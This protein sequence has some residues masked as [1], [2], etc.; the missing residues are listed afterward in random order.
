M[1]GKGKARKEWYGKS[2]KDN[3]G[4]ERKCEG[5]QGESGRVVGGEIR[6]ER[7]KERQKQR[8]A[9]KRRAYQAAR[10]AERE[11][12]Q[13]VIDVKER[14]FIHRTGKIDVMGDG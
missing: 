12:I 6:E 1:R 2:L 13:R 3:G 14:A 8:F 9:E 7:E 10:R 4:E 5:I 11:K